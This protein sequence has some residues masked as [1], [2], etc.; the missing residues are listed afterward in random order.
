MSSFIGI[1]LPTLFEI[2]IM[3]TNL[4]STLSVLILSLLIIS[5]GE[6]DPEPLPSE[7]Q[8]VLLAGAKGSSKSWKVTEINYQEGTTAVQDFDF[9]PCF[10][11][12]IY[13]FKNNDA[14]DY[15]ATEGGTKC[16]SA[17]P[18]VVESGV[19]TFTTDGKM[20]IVLPDNLTYSYNILFAFLTYPATVVE[21]TETSLKIR[22]NFVDDGVNTVYNITF[23]KS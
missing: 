10:L 6:D 12:N 18:T 14:Q 13:T 5:C 23:V 21:L 1:I 17:D 20:I 19:W 22:M 16:D 4:L 7:V 11:D 2:I 9:D 15:E 3:K 8:A